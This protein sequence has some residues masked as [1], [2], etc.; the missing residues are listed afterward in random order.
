MHCHIPFEF[1]LK[2]ELLY[3]THIVLITRYM[4]FKFQQIP[5]KLLPNRL[6]C[7]PQVQPLEPD[8]TFL[9]LL[10]G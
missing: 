10:L 2:R 7:H 3:T 4:L 9:S 1:Q 6:G 5:P 8:K